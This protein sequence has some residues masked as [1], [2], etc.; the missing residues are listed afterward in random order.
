MK[1]CLIEVRFGEVRP[2][3]IRVPDARTS[4]VRSNK[5]DLSEVYTV[6]HHT[7]QIGPDEVH[8]VK[9]RARYFSF[10]QVGITQP[11]FFEVSPAQIRAAQ[12]CIPQERPVQISAAKIGTAE[13]NFLTGSL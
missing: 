1:D 5:F 8:S 11:C 12:I 7:A 6:K 9:V 2:G 13:I 3:E 10:R 4:D